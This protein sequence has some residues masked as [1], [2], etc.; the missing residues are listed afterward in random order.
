[1]TNP[2]FD[3][4]RSIKKVLFGF[5]GGSS[6]FDNI[7]DPVEFIGYVSADVV[8]PEPLIE[9]KN[10]LTSVLDELT[11]EGGQKF[12]ARL[13]DPEAGDGQVA[14]DIAVQYGFQPMAASLFD[15]TRFY[16]YLTLHNNTETV[17]QIP[18]PEAL[19]A[20]SL[21]RGI[22]EGLK[23]YASGLLKSV[24]LAVPESPPPYMQQQGMPPGNE[25]TQLQSFLINDFDL[26]SDDLQTGVVPAEA[27]LLI[28][29]DPD[30]YTEQQVFAMDQFLMK[31]GTVVVATGAFAAQPTQGALTA[32]NRSSG[33]ADWLRHNGVDVGET[34]VMDPQ[35]SAFPVPITRQAG[36][37]SFQDLVMLDY[38]YFVDVRGDGFNDDSPILAGLPQITLSWASPLT[39]TAADGVVA[40]TLLSSSPESWLSA[41]TNVMPRVD[42]QGLTGFVPTGEQ[43]SHTLAVALEGRFTSYYSGQQ[44]PLLAAAEEAAEAESSE[45]EAT[46]ADAVELGIVTSVIERSPESARLLVFASNDFLADQTLRMIGSA[47][48]TLY[49][50]SI[51]MLANVVDWALEDQNLIGIRARG[52]F[53]R[54][55]PGM[56]IAQQSFIE[57]LNYA[58]ALLGVGVVMYVFRRRAKRQAE[59]QRGWFQGSAGEQS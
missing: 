3:V 55:L 41:D 32:V 52:N 19:S 13:V 20:E 53:N 30:G 31:G 38:P 11:I 57:Y 58:L 33:V 44:S 48:G 9:L 22:E 14:V 28:V 46:D 25:F 26:V 24:V 16:F 35:N 18:I 6:L 34:L 56:E 17:V 47:D 42:E 37:F 29:A 43:S 2:E 54:T 45:A 10:T 40:T 50:N 49:G 59:I 21:K 36:G 7:T 39:V 5:Q 23:R 51:Q 12:S 27:D 8:L 15:E 4:T 1:L